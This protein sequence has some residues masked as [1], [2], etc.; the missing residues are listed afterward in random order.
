MKSSISPQS[1]ARVCFLALM[2]GNSGFEDKHPSYIEEKVHMLD[3]GIE[4]FLR[5]DIHNMRKVNLWC[6]KWNVEMP[7][8][9]AD[10]L[11]ASEEAYE[12]LL[13]KGVEL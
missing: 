3:M 7:K 1:F 8:D 6:Q 4:A 12:E 5:L 11:R 10:Y 9:C 2:E 13:A